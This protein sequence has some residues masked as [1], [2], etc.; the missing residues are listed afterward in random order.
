MLNVIWDFIS[1]SFWSSVFSYELLKGAAEWIYSYFK[2]RDFNGKWVLSIYGD[3]KNV[4]SIVCLK[5]HAGGF[6]SIKDIK[7]KHIPEED[8]LNNVLVNIS[9]SKAKRNH[10]C[11]TITIDAGTGNNGIAS[12]TMRPA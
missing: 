8:I 2:N 10:M 6:I 12:L 9:Q 7:Q 3:N 5:Q 11:L 4:F 1:S